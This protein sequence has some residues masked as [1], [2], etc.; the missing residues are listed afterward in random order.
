VVGLAS[1]GT[2]ARRRRRYG[3]LAPAAAAEAQLRELRFALPRFGLG[4]GSGVTLLDLERLAG[5]GLRPRTANYLAGLR[6]SRYQP[7]DP[8]P[9]TLAARR[10][11]RRELADSSGPGG[12]L[13]ALLAI[14]PGGPR[15]RS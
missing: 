8:K 3:S 7:R 9:P 11:V 15:L 14:P 2:V 10:I 4:V 13:R 5:R 1:W 6:A 12:R